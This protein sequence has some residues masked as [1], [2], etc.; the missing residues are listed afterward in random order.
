MELR[1]H[2]HDFRGHPCGRRLHGLVRQAPFLFRG[3]RPGNG[4]NIDD[5]YSPEINS[6]PVSL[7][8]VP[9]CNPLPDQTPVA[10]S[11]AW[12]DSFQNIQCYDS[13][14]VQ[15]VLNEINGKTHNG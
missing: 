14:K 2:Q 12:T 1:P 6:I 4:T 9:G 8:S 13:L 11:N 5:Y 10:A 7:P 3:F 15:A